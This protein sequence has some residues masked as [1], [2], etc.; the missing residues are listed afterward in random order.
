MYTLN[1]TD[2]SC[3]G[4][5]SHMSKALQDPDSTH[6]HPASLIEE[7]MLFTQLL[8][9]TLNFSKVMPGQCREQMMLDLIVQSS[10]THRAC[11]QK[12]NAKSQL[13]PVVSDQRGSIMCSTGV[14]G[15]CNSLSDK[16]QCSKTDIVQMPNASQPT[17]ILHW[18]R[19]CL[20]VNQSFQTPETISLVETTCAVTKSFSVL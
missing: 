9:T 1:R 16:A 14:D 15:A 5:R 10:C 4:E 6:C 13:E 17:K 20:P 12:L 3:L 2:V 19:I 8:H 18:G 11:W 7:T